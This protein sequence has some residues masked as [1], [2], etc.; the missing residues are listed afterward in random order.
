MDQTHSFIYCNFL[1]QL[2]PRE[3]VQ[4]GLWNPCKAPTLTGQTT[5][6]GESYSVVGS[7]TSPTKH[8]REDAGDG[9]Y[10]LSF[11]S[12]KTRKSRLMQTS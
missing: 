12:E 3:K 2:C 7:L 8:D 1:G 5:E 11:L 9:T 6:P 4:R 10:G